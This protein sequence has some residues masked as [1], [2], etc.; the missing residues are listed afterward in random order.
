MTPLRI[1]GVSDQVAAH[2]RT[3]IRKGIW[4]ELMPGGDRLAR[5]LGVGRST[6][7][8]ALKSLEGEGLLL[9]QG[10]GRRRRIAVSDSPVGQQLRVRILPYDREE[11]TGGSFHEVL[12]RIQAAGHAAEFTAQSLVGLKMDARRVAK[13]VA[14]TPADAWV[15]VGGS[16][17][18]LATFAKGPVPAFAMV[19]RMRGIPIAGVKPD[20]SPA[21]IDAVRRLVALGHSR[22]V[23]LV[24]PER[25]HPVPGTVEQAFLNELRS[26]GIPT[27]PYNLAVW[28]GGRAEFHER[29]DSIFR[30]TPPTALFLDEPGLFIAAQQHLARRGILAPDHVSLVSND[31]DPYFEML[32][33]QVSHID[34]SFDTLARQM[35]RWLKHVAC[36]RDDRQ[37]T[38]V[39]ATFI[40]GG[41][42]GPAPDSRADSLLSRG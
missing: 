10:T 9:P 38:F 12:H 19:G 1:L 27:G 32:E 18:V 41:T 17:E 2:L 4:G 20:K 34:W 23:K 13:L 36:G 30:H 5:E 6:I 16:Q 35:V 24:T 39:K 42:I 31:P 33:P 11:R 15:V 28:N 7:D 8:L 29:L 3:E 14:N 25:V 21:Q 40:E 37:Q 22:I 26:L